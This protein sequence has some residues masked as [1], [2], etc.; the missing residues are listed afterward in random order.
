MRYLRLYMYASVVDNMS[1]PVLPFSS[2]KRTIDPLENINLRNVNRLFSTHFPSDNVTKF[3]SKSMRSDEFKLS[4][5]RRNILY[6][7]AAPPRR[8]NLALTIGAPAQRNADTW[9]LGDITIEAALTGNARRWLSNWHTE[10][11]GCTLEF[12]QA[13]RP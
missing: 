8:L 12:V 1:F 2:K 13:H 7:R 6:H 4:Q 10:F 11:W 9:Q 5:K 3:L